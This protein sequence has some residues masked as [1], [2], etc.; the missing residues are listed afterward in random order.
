M[1]CNQCVVDIRIRSY[2]SGISMIRG[3]WYLYFLHDKG[4]TPSIGKIFQFQL[5]QQQQLEEVCSSQVDTALKGPHLTGCKCANHVIQRFIYGSSHKIAHITTWI[6]KHLVSDSG[7][8]FI[9]L[10]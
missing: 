2:Y 3:Y 10:T 8:L 4:L 1:Q 6:S 7:F 9:M 5:V